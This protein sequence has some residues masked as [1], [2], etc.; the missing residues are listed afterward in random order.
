MGIAQGELD[1]ALDALKKKDP[2]IRRA[3]D[4][5]GYPPTRHRPHAFE[6]LLRI[7]V[8]QQ[9]STHAAN[10]IYG[11][12]EASLKGDVSPSALLRKRA[13]TL[14]RVGLSER[15]VEYV[16]GRARALHTGEIDLKRMSK[17]SDE[18]VVATITAL[19]G[20]GPWSA[21]MYLMMALGRL[22]VWPI[23]D[24][25][26]RAGVQQ[27]LELEER[28]SVKEMPELGASWRPNRSAVALLAWHI[29]HSPPV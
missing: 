28:P 15:K 5:I 27:L 24:L 22:D 17:M 6:T 21:Q 7:V 19:R 26:V 10:A 4:R 12:L 14:R 23:D 11:R 20:F 2:A 3:L 9:V 18:D 13:T 8:G 29:L 16:R 25:G 1:A